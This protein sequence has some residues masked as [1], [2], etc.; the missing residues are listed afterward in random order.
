[1]ITVKSIV[2]G[3]A[4]SGY[5]SEFSA[6]VRIETPDESYVA[7]PEWIF[8]R[9]PEQKQRDLD[10]QIARIRRKFNSEPRLG[11]PGDAEEISRELFEELEKE[12]RPER[13]RRSR[14]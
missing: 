7:L 4:S 9:T 12:E 8:R 6:P 5:D 3:D 14:R 1:M 2:F 11:N 13:I 10:A